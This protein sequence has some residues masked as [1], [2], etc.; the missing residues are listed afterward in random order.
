MDIR[1]FDSKDEQEIIELWNRCGLIRSWNDP[2]KDIARKLAMQPEWFFVGLL[3]D[4]II[5][6]VMAG[7]DG[8]RGWLYYLAVDPDH[9][10]KGYGRKIVD[11]AEKALRAAGCPKINLQVRTSNTRVIEFYKR[12]GFIEDEVL[13]M[14]KRLCD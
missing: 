3:K 9:Q 1:I 13:S 4:T 6:S 10:G 2:H 7:Y 14:G 12:I 8:H 11:E 5:S